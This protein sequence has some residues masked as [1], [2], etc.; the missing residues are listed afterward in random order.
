M[1]ALRSACVLLLAATL[2]L[3]FQ[4]E[5]DASSPIHSAVELGEGMEAQV[6][7]APVAL[8]QEDQQ[9]LHILDAYKAANAKHAATEKVLRNKLMNPPEKAEGVS[10]NAIPGYKYSYLGR[11]MHGK[12]RASCESLC[13]TY[14]ACKSYSYNDKTRTCVWSMSQLKYDPDFRMYAKKSAPVGNPEELYAE[15][16]GMLMQDKVK[17]RVKG[18][19]K[20]ECKYSCTKD[21]G[22]KTFSYSESKSEC[23]TSGVPLHYTADFTYYEKNVPLGPP[24][25]KKKHA[26]ENAGKEQL[27]ERWIKASTKPSRQSI[28]KQEKTTE[29]LA[30]RRKAAVSKE[31]I[32]KTNRGAYNVVEKRC[33]VTRSAFS[34]AMQE[35]AHL[36]SKVSAAN[37][38][39]IN[40]QAACEKGHKAI[41]NAAK[42]HYEAGQ[43][44]KMKASLCD[45]ASK[46]KKEKH[47]TFVRAERRQKVR[48]DK[49]H[50]ARKKACASK[51]SAKSLFKASEASMKKS[52]EKAQEAKEAKRVAFQ[53]SV[54]RNDKKNQYQAQLSMDA[55][56]KKLA[57]ANVVM[58]ASVKKYKTSDTE[59]SRK[60]AIQDKAKAEDSL[61]KQKDKAS[62]LKLDLMKKKEKTNKSRESLK[63]DNE[64]KFKAAKKVS[65]K[66]KEIA[67][68]KAHKAAKL[69]AKKKAEKNKKAAKVA[70]MAKQREAAAKRIAQSK[71]NAEKAQK[72][73]QTDAE[74]RNQAITVKERASK[75]LAHDKKMNR[76]ADE[77][78]GK[79][80]K[81]LGKN[82]KHTKAQ[83]RKDQL[84]LNN[85]QRQERAAKQR[86][87]QARDVK[88]K[89][90]KTHAR[91]EK[92][93]KRAA[94]TVQRA[95]NE[96]QAKRSQ[97][98][99]RSAKSQQG[100]ANEKLHKA[101][102]NSAHRQKLAMRAS[103]KVKLHGCKQICSKGREVQHKSQ[104]TN[105][106]RELRG[107]SNRA[108]GKHEELSLI[109]MGSDASAGREVAKK[110]AKAKSRSKELAMKAA[111]VPTKMNYRAS[112]PF[113]YKGCSC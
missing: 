62:K 15:L 59:R 79:M 53:I 32:E 63:K 25:W 92:G 29:K 56:E 97:V 94:T 51:S 61:K 69:A 44:A 105:R 21:V 68:K 70:Q 2:A 52:E 20:P 10:Y 112:K 41:P 103:T 26:K 48:K 47:A 33:I 18:I 14:G 108:K 17:G 60:A 27:K 45:Q 73:V 90:S 84:Q 82:E 4:P 28:E 77:A 87:M 83:K 6:A 98:A 11:T 100:H 113:R 65:D 58:E 88:E 49:A 5:D 36:L 99:E 50:E 110:M 54:Y 7:K 74:K 39:S 30:A 46:E 93:S 76:R 101:T 24:D 37:K 22:C 8:R 40:K 16:P 89:A 80:M 111:Q 31:R 86:A 38:K 102:K 42:K 13:N 104:I 1:V 85:L 64:K 23:L 78:R 109:D 35:N 75:D 67:K 71:S 9:A 96:G 95:K 66:K 19:S 43:K 72:K 81:K 12:S 34:A 106:A 91:K 3:S 55:G 107:K 57:T